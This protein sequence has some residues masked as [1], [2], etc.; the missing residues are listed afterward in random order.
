VES[1]DQREHGV[2]EIENEAS[3]STGC[4]LSLLSLGYIPVFFTL[5]TDSLI[6]RNC[7]SNENTAY[8]ENQELLS[9]KI[10][11]SIY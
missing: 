9:S 11:Y 7:S 3:K 8:T 2:E 10:S 6:F 4:R 1:N 5:A